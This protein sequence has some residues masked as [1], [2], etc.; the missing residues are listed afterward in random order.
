V[1]E[2]KDD[3]QANRLPLIEDGVVGFW[4]SGGEGNDQANS[5]KCHNDNQRSI[6][7]KTS[8]KLSPQ[9]AQAS[10]SLSVSVR[11]CKRWPCAT[12]RTAC[13]PSLPVSYHSTL[14]YAK[15]EYHV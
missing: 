4:L 14:E 3:S 7:H 1:V 13:A 9:Q 8:Y 11:Y 15:H 5:D 2:L 10:L 6:V 12:G